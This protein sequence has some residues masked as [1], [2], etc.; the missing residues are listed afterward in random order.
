VNDPRR[1]AFVVDS[2]T[3]GGAEQCIAQLVRGLP[4]T[5]ARAVLATEPVPWQLASAVREAGWP[6]LPLPPVRGTAAGAAQ[7]AEAVAALRPDVVHVNLIDPATCLDVLRG[8]VGARR[9]TVADVHMTGTIGDSETRRS[10][11]LA[12]RDCAAVIAR[13]GQIGE[14]VRVGL[15]VPTGRVHVVR[16]GAPV[17]AAAAGTG[18]RP[19]PVRIRAVGRLTR[20]KGFDLLV[21]AT[22]R[23]LAAGFDIDVAVAGDGRD[24]EVLA[25]AAQGLPV[26]LAGF[27]SDVPAFLAD[28]D[29]FCLP[30][31]AEA[32][33]LALL[34]AVLAGLPCVACDV[35]DVAAA[36]ADLAIVVPPE[37]VEALAAALAVLAA[38]PALRAELGTRARR[39]GVARFDER[40]TVAAVGA[41][42]RRALAVG[43]A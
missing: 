39:E 33:P 15:A 8:A 37:D 7:V 1:V 16:N 29:I 36:L 5:V 11:R 6:L 43:A 27:V 12:Y 4:P 31:R 20:Q 42:Y 18:S 13:S 40:T 38:D 35:G 10:L 26:R 3:Y 9:C 41:V 28:A 24:R 34:E 32:L 19:G 25:V 21:D 2:P 17:R 30:S 22:R 23:L 14:L